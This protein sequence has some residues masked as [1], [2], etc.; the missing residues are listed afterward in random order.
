MELQAL[1]LTEDERT[2][3]VLTKL[4][5]DLE[6][7]VKDCAQVE[8]ASELLAGQ[9]FDGILLDCDMEGSRN[10]LSKARSHP[11]NKRSIIFAILSSTMTVGSAFQ[12]GANFIFYKPVSL[13]RTRRSL[14]AARGLMMRE[15]RRHF[16]YALEAPVFLTMEEG[17]EVRAFVVDLSRGGMAIRVPE[18]PEMKQDVHLRVALPGMATSLEAQG[19]VVWADRYGR[20]GLHFAAMAEATRRELDRWL[21]EKLAELGAPEGAAE[22]RKAEAPP[23]EDAV[24]EMEE[25]EAG[26]ARRFRSRWLYR[27]RCQAPLV[28]VV[29][30]Q[31]GKTV[32]LR[33]TCK[34]LNENGMGAELMGELLIGDSVLLEL[35]LPNLDERLKLHANV[36]HRQRSHY[37][38][39]F[40]SLTA[41]QLRIIQHFVRS[42]N[43]E[44]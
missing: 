14:R 40:V 28:V 4:L 3:R 33:G 39:E 43:V 38:F 20:A 36:R 35:S 30:I 24:I 9:K 41:E 8:A 15:R 21:S 44:E 2:L 27:G 13:E 18:A 1:I 6:I 26:P 12:L 10:L 11:E 17:K 16:R 31:G 22:G 37:G 29:T 34:D 42:L 19:K 5:E 32:V 25:E 7:R 23:P